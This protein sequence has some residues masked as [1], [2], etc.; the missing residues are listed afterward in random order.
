[1]N[2]TVPLSEYRGI[3]MYIWL[4]YSRNHK[5]FGWFLGFPDISKAGIFKHVVHFSPKYLAIHF[6]KDGINKEFNGKS[7]HVAA[8]YGGSGCFHWVDKPIEE[9]IPNWL[10]YK[11]NNKFEFFIENDDGAEIRA[12]GD[13]AAIDVEISSEKFPGADIEAIYEYGVGLW[14]RWLMNYPFILLEKAP[15]HSIFR[16]TTNVEYGDEDKA[17][18]RTL[19]VFV[20]R[21]EYQFIT[22]DVNTN[23]NAIGSGIK[24]D[25]ELEGY[26]SFIYF[27]YKRFPEGPRGVGQVFFTNLGLV[28]RVEV[29][30]AKN[31]LMRDKARLVVGKKEF[32]H[33]AF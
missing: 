10:P 19:A 22:Y 30:S 6:G 28:K 14:T 13:N 16:L 3:W 26:W 2:K 7:R 20:G 29:E 18:D 17:G 9:E 24:Y 27:S 5:T 21:N 23:N 11:L 31:W 32:A 15:S 8:C 25:F 12:D 1:M 4:G 33:S